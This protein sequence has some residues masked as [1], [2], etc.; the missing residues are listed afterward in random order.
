MKILLLILWFTTCASAA[1]K[2]EQ[3]TANLKVHPTQRTVPVEFKFSNTGEAPVTIQRVDVSCGC[4]M[5]KIKNKTLAPGEQGVLTIVFYLDNRRGPQE[6]QVLVIT[7]DGKEV[8]LTIKTDIPTSYLVEPTLM[9][10]AVD[11]PMPVKKVKLTNKNPFPIQLL[12]AVSS[13][14]KVPVELK[15]IRPGYEY[16]LLVP[17][18]PAGNKIRS[19]IRIKTEPPAGETESKDLTL[20][21]LAE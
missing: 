13:N 1:L 4:L 18:P 21:V 16:E 12:S 14:E 10:W 19:V 3:Q 11:N 17:R 2:W 9:K 20:Y 15:A 5:P 8:H 7:D 6:K